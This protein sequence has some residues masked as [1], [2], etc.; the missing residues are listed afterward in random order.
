MVAWIV[1]GD[2][3]PKADTDKFLTEGDLRPLSDSEN[4]NTVTSRLVA[5]GTIGAGKTRFQESILQL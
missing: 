4:P 2:E 3:A 5:Y 1:I